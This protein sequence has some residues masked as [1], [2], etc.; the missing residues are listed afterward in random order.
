MPVTRDSTVRHGKVRWLCD[1]PHGVARLRVDSDAFTQLPLS[2]PN[3]KPHPG[4]TTPGELLAVAYAAFMAADLAARLEHN[5][6]P[7]SELVVQAW[8]RLSSNGVQRS[9]EQIDVSVRG[10]VA[11]IGDEQF[12]AIAQVALRSSHKATGMRRDVPRDLDVSLAA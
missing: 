3:G 1:P 7:A 11:G 2:M 12:Q 6:I 10:R 4:E 9:V 5:G 8:C